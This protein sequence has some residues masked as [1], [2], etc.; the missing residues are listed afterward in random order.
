ATDL[1]TSGT[2]IGLDL[3]GGTLTIKKTVF[4]NAF[5]ASNG[6]ILNILNDTENTTTTFNNRNSSVITFS[7]GTINIGSADGDITA[8]AVFNA[9]GGVNIGNGTD[10]TCTVNIFPNGK[11]SVEGSAPIRVSH[12]RS[13][14]VGILNVYGGTISLP[15]NEMQLGENNSADVGAST[16]NLFSG[17]VTLGTISL[18]RAGANTPQESRAHIYNGNLTVNTY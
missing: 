6:S 12:S 3:T 15:N 17:N 10:N 18:P 4:S 9:K 13:N 5:G 7:D 11:L 16:L 2:S 8:I 1:N 14:A